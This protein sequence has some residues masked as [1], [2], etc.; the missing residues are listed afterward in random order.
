MPDGLGLSPAQ[1][2]SQAADAD[3]FNYSL[4]RQTVA[5]H[6]GQAWTSYKD[7][8]RRGE[9]GPISDP[10]PP[11]LPPANPPTPVPAGVEGRFR[12]LMRLVR[13]SPGYNEGIGRD[14]GAV[15]AEHTAPDLAAVQPELEVFVQ[16]GKVQVDWD[17][18]GNSAY[19]DMI[20]LRVDRGD[21]NGRVLLAHDTT[22]GYTDSTPFPATP[23]KWTYS[24]IFWVNDRPVGQWSNPVTVVVSA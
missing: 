7:S 20:E 4:M 17:W 18:G 3:F 12:A 8:V 22:P 15:G 2:A 24:A 23:T 19:L 16:G 5:L 21:G 6:Q 14:L 10:P 1:V 9:A 13:A 11:V